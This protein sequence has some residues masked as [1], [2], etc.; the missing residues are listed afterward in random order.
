M[1]KTCFFGLSLGLC[2]LLLSF[3]ADVLANITAGDLDFQSIT[4]TIRSTAP[5]SDYTRFFIEEEQ[6]SDSELDYF[7]SEPVGCLAPGKWPPRSS[8]CCDTQ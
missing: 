1:K 8:D 7:L 2:S 4:S 5:D 6:A 3:N